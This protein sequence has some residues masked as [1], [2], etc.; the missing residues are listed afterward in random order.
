MS[1]YS[2]VT[3]ER[4]YWWIGIFFLAAILWSIG[5]GRPVDLPNWHEFDYSSIARNFV[6]EGSNILLPRID[7]RGDGP[8]YT[9][10][11]FPLIP[12]VM[13]QLYRVFGIHEVIGRIL[14]L[15]FSLGALWVFSRIALKVLPRFAAMIATL[16]LA[17]NHE[18]LMIATAIQPEALMLLCSLLAVYWFLD[19]YETGSRVSYA[20]AVVAFSL[21]MLVKSPAAHLAIF[22]LT[23]ALVQDGFAAFRKPKLY[24]FAALSFLAPLLW[25]A[26]AASLWHQFHNSMGVS[27]EDHWIGMDMLRRPKVILNLALIDVA[28]VFG[29]GGVLVVFAAVIQGKFRTAANRLGLSW[30]LAAVIYLV[31][32]MRTAG[33]N[34]AAYY[35]VVAAPPIALLFAAGIWQAAR[36]NK[37]ISWLRIVLWVSL[38]ALLVIGGLLWLDHRDAASLPGVLLEFTAFSPLTSISMVLTVLAVLVTVRCCSAQEFTMPESAAIPF[39]VV[40]GC[41]TYFMLSFQL[42]LGSWKSFALRSPKFEAA[43]QMRGA[44]RPGALIVASGGICED[45]GGHRVAHDAPNMFYWLD[46]KGFTTCAGRQSL[47]EL[48]TDKDRGAQYFVVERDTL[49]AQPGFDAELRAHY[50]LLKETKAAELFSLT[51]NQQSR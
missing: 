31:V 43:V 13:A 50:Q 46:R 28:Y 44:L 24:L 5:I 3:R 20:G 12:W 34:W 15:L 48:Q 19:W 4:S 22:F 27:N 25:Y 21:A 37:S 2:G 29:V 7:W 30:W 45:A 1:P 40:I 18:M 42:A 14:S 26:H 38:P 17:V 9:E 39:Y 11:E 41:F 49:Q 6:R 35:H 32:I 16:F 36:G 23:W 10:M 33:A 51:A 8:G 47:A